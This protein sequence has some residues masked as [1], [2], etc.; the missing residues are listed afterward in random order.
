M[1]ATSPVTLS[2]TDTNNCMTFDLFLKVI[3]SELQNVS[4]DATDSVLRQKSF[5]S[6]REVDLRMP[7]N[8]PIVVR[9]D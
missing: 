3:N 1:S 4:R 2:E 7:I 5:D 8:V 6:M 9:D